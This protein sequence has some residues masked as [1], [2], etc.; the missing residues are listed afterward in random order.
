MT[1]EPQFWYVC[2]VNS[3]ILATCPA[4]EFRDGPRAVELAMKAYEQNPND[5]NVLDTLAAAYA[6]AGDVEAAVQWSE[7]ALELAPDN[8][9]L[10]EHLDCFRDGRPWREEVKHN[11]S[12]R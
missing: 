11:Q 3:W 6:E 8:K 2:M 12:G 4:D 1:L 10:I 5:L 7:R 9:E